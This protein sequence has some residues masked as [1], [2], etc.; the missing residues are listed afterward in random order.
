MIYSIFVVAHLFIRA[1]RTIPRS[2]RLAHKAPA[3]QATYTTTQID[4]T[5]AVPLTRQLCELTKIISTILT[6]NR[7]YQE[8]FSNFELS[9]SISLI[10]N[11]LTGLTVLKT[12]LSIFRNANCLTYFFR[13]KHYI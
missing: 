3:I 4:N 11:F 1:S 2:P 12:V 10:F 7:G 6:F 13:Q 8:C 5:K 9:T